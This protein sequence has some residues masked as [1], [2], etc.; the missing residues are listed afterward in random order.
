MPL[1][2]TSNRVEVNSEFSE[3]MQLIAVGE[4]FC[5]IREVDYLFCLLCCDNLLPVVRNG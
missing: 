4:C 1:C 3:Y 5:R 2:D